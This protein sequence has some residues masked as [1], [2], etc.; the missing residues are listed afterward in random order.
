MWYWGWAEFD[1]EQGIDASGLGAN[2]TMEQKQ[3]QEMGQMMLRAW[4]E[5]V[6]TWS[7]SVSKVEDKLV[8]LLVPRLCA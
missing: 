7:Q 1:R 4:V 3:E 5:K 8:Q 2:M 6:G